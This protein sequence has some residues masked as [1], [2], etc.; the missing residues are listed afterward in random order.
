MTAHI[1][2]KDESP[3]EDDLLA[4]ALTGADGRLSAEFDAEP[5]QDVYVRFVAANAQWQV[6][7]A[8]GVTYEWH[9]CVF[10]DEGSTARG[11]CVVNV[12]TYVIGSGGGPNAR[13]QS[14]GALW[15]YDA[16]R[17][18]NDFARAHGIR[19]GGEERIKIAWPVEEQSSYVMENEIFLCERHAAQRDIILH[20]IGHTLMSAASAIPSGAGGRHSVERAYNEQLAWAEGWATFFAGCVLYGDAER[21]PVMA[22]FG[23]GLS[24]ESLPGRIAAGERNE[25][26][27]A[28][29]LWDLYDVGNESGDEIGVSFE[30]MWR[31][32][33]A[34]DG[35][36][37]ESLREFVEKLVQLNAA[38][39]ETVAKI[40]RTLASGGI[41]Y[42]LAKLQAYAAAG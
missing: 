10:W 12:G 42:D 41:V 5:Y 26:R 7:T 33:E 4:V 9:T 32:L 27:V 39:G 22:H 15:I 38:D 13:R 2:D 11:T 16:A 37:I 19:L 6:A 34:S 18:A 1:Y 25:M 30:A 29:A 23:G 8:K 14:V 17:A 40:Q 24:L 3:D 28:A 36:A 31:V 35:R 21:N 20:E